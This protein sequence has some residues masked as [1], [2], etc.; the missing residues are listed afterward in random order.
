MTTQVHDT[1]IFEGHAFHLCRISAPPL[2]DLASLGL[3]P[4]MASTACYRGWMACYSVSS[5]LL[6]A[7]LFVRHDCG[8]PEPEPCGPVIDGVAP[9]DPRPFLGFNCLYRALARPVPFS[10][11]L[12]IG[13][14]AHDG[15]CGHGALSFGRFDQLYELVFQEGRLLEAWDRSAVAALIRAGATIDPQRRLTGVAAGLSMKYGLPDNG[16]LEALAPRTGS[17]WTI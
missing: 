3:N 14:G 11:G 15:A 9:A 10:G 4:V 8:M 1:V 16:H 5:R 2:F 13:R 17:L 6:L 12:L 7:D